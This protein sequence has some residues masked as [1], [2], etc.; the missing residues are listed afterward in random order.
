MKIVCLATSVVLAFEPKMPVCHTITN[1]P[2][3]IKHYLDCDTWLKSSRC[4]ILV[5]YRVLNE[6]KILPKDFLNFY[7]ESF[8]KVRTKTVSV[9]P[10]SRIIYT[11][12]D[13]LTKVFVI[14][15]NLHIGTDSDKIHVLSLLLLL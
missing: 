3:Q 10:I 13:I 7:L 14:E 9:L 4:C 2:S 6:D 8:Q 11:E 1:L 15:I 5:D 12:E